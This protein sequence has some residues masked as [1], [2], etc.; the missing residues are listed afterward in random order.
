A[1]TVVE[2]VLATNTVYSAA[3]NTGPW[4]V[5]DVTDGTDPGV[6]GTS[7]G[8][9][10]PDWIDCERFLQM[11]DEVTGV[12]DIVCT[13]PRVLPPSA[14][15]RVIFVN[16]DFTLTAADSGAGLL[17]VTGRLTMEGAASWNGIIVV[18]GEGEFLR[19]PAG[20]GTANSASRCFASASSRVIPAPPSCAVGNTGVGG[21]R[22][23]AVPI[24]AAISVACSASSMP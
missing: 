15:D 12:A 8:I 3:S 22:C 7:L 13:P 18:A 9:I 21:S 2:G 17:W 4:T 16:G 6:M 24:S 1:E 20:T 11:A 19:T 23:Q 14:P 10:D 5:V